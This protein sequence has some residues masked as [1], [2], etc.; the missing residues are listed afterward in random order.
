MSSGDLSLDIVLISHF[1]RPWE[2]VFIYIK[3][4]IFNWLC[5]QWLVIHT[6]KWKSCLRLMPHAVLYIIFSF[7]W[8]L[9]LAI[10]PHHCRK[11][12]LHSSFFSF[13]DNEFHYI[14]QIELKVFILQTL[15]PECWD[16]RYA[17]S[18]RV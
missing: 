4:N 7:L 11:Q 1:L 3:Y 18:H 15:S 6:I 12:N 8:W 2:F 10:S 9:K 17:S 14:P 16:Y 13:F 5:L